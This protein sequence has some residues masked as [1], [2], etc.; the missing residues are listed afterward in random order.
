[1]KCGG[2]KALTKQPSDDTALKCHL[3]L[4]EPK[5]V[6]ASTLVI[7][8][9]QAVP[10]LEDKLEVTSIRAEV[11]SKV[12]V[13]G[14]ILPELYDLEDGVETEKPVKISVDLDLYQMEKV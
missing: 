4:E 12:S 13:L 10:E 3:A 8:E 14:K 2:G 5:T 1:L 11:K 7:C 9:R 6:E